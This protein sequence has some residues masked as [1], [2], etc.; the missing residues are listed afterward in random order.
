MK[1]FRLIWFFIIGVIITVFIAFNYQRGK[2]VVP[3]SEIFPDEEVF[4]VDVEY[5]FIKKGE[6]VEIQ[7]VR[8]NIPEGKESST[9]SL[10]KK[11]IIAEE[12]KNVSSEEKIQIQTVTKKSLF[13]I[14]VASFKDKEKAQNF[15]ER[16]KKEG[17]PAYIVSRNLG[18]KGV[19]YRVYVGKFDSKSQ[20]EVFLK[21]FS[22]KYK[23][24]FIIS[25]GK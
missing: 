10:P 21:K 24:C 16:L 15:F 3:L 9:V 20:A 25:P 19:W 2:D 11:I 23:D 14:Q 13:T 4:P 8:V 22:G 12:K 1:N 18:A 6:E 17:H 7:P 5:E